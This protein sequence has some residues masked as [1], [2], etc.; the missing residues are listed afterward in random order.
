MK[1]ITTPEHAARS[2]TKTWGGVTI[3]AMLE[4]IADIRANHPHL[5]RYL[6]HPEIISG[7]T[8]DRFSPL[9]LPLRLEQMAAANSTY[10]RLALADTTTKLIALSHADMSAA[11]CPTKP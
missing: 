7:L 10:H 11:L 4:T 1:P 8:E 3:N 6:T 2:C 5:A 9:T